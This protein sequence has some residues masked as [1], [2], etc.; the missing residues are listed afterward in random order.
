M[1]ESQQDKQTLNGASNLALLFYTQ[2]V[3]YRYSISILLWIVSVTLSNISD[4]GFK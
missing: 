2:G 1:I 4:Y 3:L